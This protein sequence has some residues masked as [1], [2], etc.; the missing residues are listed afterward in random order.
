M[1][2][3]DGGI[4]SILGRAMSFASL[5]QTRQPRWTTDD[6]R[7]LRDHLLTMTDKEIGAALGRTE[8]AVHLRRER[9][10]CLPARSK[11]PGCLTGNRM[12]DV[13]GVDVHTIMRLVALGLL[14]V[15]RTVGKRGIFVIRRQTLYRWA[16][17]PMRWPYFQPWRG[18]VTDPHLRRLIA[19]QM[20]RWGDEWLTPG[21]AAELCGVSSNDVNRY[22]RTGRLSGVR[23]G[24][25]WVRRS[26]LNGLT[27]YKGRGANHPNV[28]NGKA[29]ACLLRL[30][31]AGLTYSEIGQRMNW[32]MSRVWYR[33]KVLDGGQ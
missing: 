16:I 12:A 2:N 9:D 17:N 15:G 29:D 18:R 21:Q 24:N 10:L 33:L 6:D 31:A 23:W 14:P 26:D 28:W 20:V 5:Y 27:F 11:Q 4:E 32:K 19:R 1:N 3:G 25:W 22:I 30:R 7:F 13:L 8:N